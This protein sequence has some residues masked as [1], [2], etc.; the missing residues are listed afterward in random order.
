[1]LVL[2]KER[3]R[4]HLLYSMG[5]KSVARE[6]GMLSFSLGSTT[7]QLWPW[8]EVAYISVSLAVTTIPT[9]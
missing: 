1:M 5:G 7:D 2:Q 4:T 9:S 3:L 8:E 6:A